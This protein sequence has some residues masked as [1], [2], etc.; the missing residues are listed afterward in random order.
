MLIA[1]VVVICKV[2]QKCSYF[3]LIDCMQNLNGIYFANSSVSEK[4]NVKNRMRKNL[5]YKRL[6]DRST[7]RLKIKMANHPKSVKHQDETRSS[8]F[9]IFNKISQ[10]Q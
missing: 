8:L 7:K 9:C 4:L 3:L 10:N 6:S 1:I 5:T 2:M